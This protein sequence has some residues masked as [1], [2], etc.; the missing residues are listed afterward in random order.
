MRRQAR[1][2]S[3]GSNQRRATG[4]GRIRP[5]RARARL[6]APALALAALALL[7]LAP[8][9]LAAGDANMASC[10]ASTE[11]SPGFR[12]YLPDC[13]AYELVTPSF[14][15]GFTP[16]PAG[17]IP[18][19]PLYP[20]NRFSPGFYPFSSYGALAGSEFSP[21]IG[22]IGLGGSVYGAARD[23]SGWATSA[24]GPPSGSFALEIQSGTSTPEGIVQQGEGG[25]PLAWVLLP[26]GEP[27]AR[28]TVYR[29]SE[30]GTFE[31]IG[32]VTE[33]EGPSSASE[34]LRLD[35]AGAG[36][37]SRIVLRAK[38][39]SSGIDPWLW[40]G[41]TT[42]KNSETLYEYDLSEAGIGT[43]AAEPK[44]IGVSDQHRLAVNAEAHL[45]SA[46]GTVLGGGNNRTLGSV[47]NDGRYLY[48]TALHSNSCTGTQPISSEIY[49]RVGGE[50][51]VAISNPSEADCEECLT[52]ATT[53]KRVEA[54]EAAKNLPPVFE[55]ASGDGS[56]AFFISYQQLFPGVVGT[57][58]KPNLYR[59]DFDGPAGHRLQLVSEVPSGTAELQ[60]PPIRYTGFSGSGE[61]AYFVAKRDL[62]VGPNPY[63][64][65]PQ[66]GARNIY[67][68]EA[69]QGE[70]GRLAFVATVPENLRPLTTHDGRFVVF[71]TVAQVTGEASAA[72]QVFEYDAEAGSLVR[73]SIGDRGFNENGLAAVNSSEGPVVAADGRVFFSSPTALAPGALDDPTGEHRN[74]YE[75]TP[76]GWAGEAEARVFLIVSGNRIESGVAGLMGIDPTGGNVYF[77]AREQLVPQYI[78]TQYA[79]YDARAEGGFPAPPEPGGECQGEGC[80]GSLAALS[81]GSGVGSSA[82]R[83]PG[84]GAIAKNGRCAHLTRAV[85]RLQSRAEHL[86]RAARKAR[87]LKRAGRLRHRARRYSQAAR[88]RSVATRR[89]RRAA[90]GTN[91]NRRAGR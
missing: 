43:A 1:A 83:G 37:L 44:L 13:R 54:E 23:E 31:S 21:T 35:E 75:W 17:F 63:G 67:M 40:P 33:T 91:D 3:A 2:T 80:Q 22:Q 71:E 86:R 50:S 76:P 77:S 84:N 55:G 56:K 68:W 29:R 34:A 41:D 72:G 89:C 70:A 59:Y 88:K 9:A 38:V 65:E 74:I 12:S 24:V 10:P 62:G 36:D 47:S 60:V 48:F 90:R 53:P 61:R 28:A 87:S 79:L 16:A 49:A 78:S 45:I 58:G 5:G 7:A 25:D 73:A 4:L 85:R 69:R 19:G 18:N 46:C 66:A 57:S 8:S 30:A 39:P 82:F 6:A 52:E 14:A 32:P 20:R 15:G 11:S 42:Q 27:G 51:T 64:D 81:P 26:L